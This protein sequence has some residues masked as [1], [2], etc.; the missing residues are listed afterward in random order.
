[1]CSS[2]MQHSMRLSSTTY[3]STRTEYREST[4]GSHFRSWM[5][6]AGCEFGEWSQEGLVTLSVAV[7]SSSVEA[8]RFGIGRA[9]CA[10]S[11]E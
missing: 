3:D 11:E 7:A 8:G 4:V 1:M 5:A 6:Y 2:L 9:S 10:R